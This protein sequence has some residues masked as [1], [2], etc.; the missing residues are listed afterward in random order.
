MMIK[1]KT[2]FALLCLMG[3]VL[4]AC[5]SDS[6]EMNIPNP[7]MDAEDPNDNMP[8]NEAPVI[9]ISN[10]ADAIEAI[11]T[12]DVSVSDAS[13]QVLSRVF[14]DDMEVFESNS[15]N[16]SFDLDPFDFLNGERTLRVV[17]SDANDNLAEES[18]TFVLRKLLFT[19][20]GSQGEVSSAEIEIFLAVNSLEGT[21]I[22]YR[23]IES[24]DDGT[25]YAPDGFAR[26]DFVIT[27]YRR[28]ISSSSLLI[29]SYADVAPGVN[30]LT[31]EE[32]APIY[33]FTTSAL[34]EGS[35][36]LDILDIPAGLSL[37]NFRGAGN[38]Y[39]TQAPFNSFDP[40]SFFYD[41]DPARIH[42]AVIFSFEGFGNTS[43]DLAN[44]RYTTINS[45]ENQTLNF[46]DFLPADDFTE[47]ELPPNVSNVRVVINGYRD[48]NNYTTDLR[49]QLFETQLDDT[50]SVSTVTIPLLNEYPIVNQ[51]INLSTADGTRYLIQQRGLLPLQIPNVSIERADNSV[52]IS[53]NYN[54][55]RI[56]LIFGINSWSYFQK[57][58]EEISIPFSTFEIPEEVSVN[59]ENS[60][61]ATNPANSLEINVNV[62]ENP[63]NLDE[64]LFFPGFILFNAFG[65]NTRIIKTLN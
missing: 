24:L 2:K 7:P 56:R 61:F 36:E 5:S 50:S 40:L 54:H 23:K 14:V 55:S 41:L 25:F 21:L 28:N 53:G 30:I 35:F 18:L 58:A 46:N 65:D 33:N 51:N 45:L 4:Y 13:D 32:A 12:I 15:K 10:L 31:L 38:F 42:E 39:F 16:F 9:S 34:I 43:F 8:D 64:A 60:D 49:N 52:L 37:S 11:T 59:I 44:Y 57:S 17:S 1:V 63:A 48:E 26:Q 22:D 19:S 3:F 6:N 62:T 20:L 27:E 47:L 29:G